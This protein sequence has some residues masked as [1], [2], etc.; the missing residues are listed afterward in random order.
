MTIPE[1]IFA[2]PTDPRHLLD[3]YPLIRTRSA[4][5]ARELVG[6]ALSPHRLDVRG[7]A[8]GFEARHNQIRLGQVSLNVLSYGAEV[9]IDPGERG[10]FYLIQLPLQ[11]RA[12]VRCDGQEAWVDPDMLSVLR[13]HAHTRMLWSSD[14]SMIMLQVPSA[15]LD[16]QRPIRQQDTESPQ[17]SFTQSRHDPAVAAWWQAVADMT[18]NLH[19][20]GAQWLRHPAAYAAMEGFLLTGLDLLRPERERTPETSL[21]PHSGRH[22]QRALEYIQAHAHESLTLDRI[23]AAAC[24][25]PRTLEAAFRRRYDQSPLAY[26]RGIRLER[27]RSA[28]QAAAAEGRQSSVTDIALQHGFVH[29]GRF[30]AYYRGRFGC[31]PSETLRGSS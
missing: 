16:R 31:A 7:D 23:A 18:R 10:D 17:F 5:E 29:M 25:S 24:V 22:L 8:P 15:V 27:V 30:S 11:G 4:E 2:L 6:R 14:C 13:P 20:H 3:N 19:S 9:E 26:A 28:L 1:S 12:C 21:N